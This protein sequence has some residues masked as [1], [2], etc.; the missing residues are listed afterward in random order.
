MP[1]GRRG[2]KMQQQEVQEIRVTIEEL[3]DKVDMADQLDQLH[4]NRAFK[5]LI[6]DGYFINRA[7]E[8][9]KTAGQSSI[10]EISA[11]VHSNALL[12]ISGLQGYF[13][14]IYVEGANAKQSIDEHNELLNQELTSDGK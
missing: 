7:V 4:K 9:A 11:K 6:L 13:N 14:S 1:T 3:Q 8:L 5:K 12:G 2:I 10:N